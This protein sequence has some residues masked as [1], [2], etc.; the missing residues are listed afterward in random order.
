MSSSVWLPCTLQ[1]KVKKGYQSLT[2]QGNLRLPV[3]AN[4][5]PVACGVV[6][7]SRSMLKGR[8]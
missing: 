7:Y 4:T 3:S 8:E 2:I 1:T 6:Q 5:L